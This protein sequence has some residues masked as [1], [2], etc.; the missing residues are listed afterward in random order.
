MNH[1]GELLFTLLPWLLTA[2]V[3]A[4]MIEEL[5]L[6]PPSVRNKRRPKRVFFVPIRLHAFATA[7]FADQPLR[8]RH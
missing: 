7:L 8:Q 2:L 3:L 1:G 6:P 4:A 5:D